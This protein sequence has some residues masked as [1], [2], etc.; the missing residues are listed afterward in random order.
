MVQGM[1]TL[2]VRVRV[3]PVLFCP[4]TFEFNGDNGVVFSLI[5]ES[6]ARN[7]PAWS[8]FPLSQKI[9]FQRN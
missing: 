6:A 9:S 8:Q 3:F 2:L 5:L 1:L 7:L 4:W